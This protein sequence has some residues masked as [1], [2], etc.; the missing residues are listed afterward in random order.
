MFQW[1]FNI[2]GN[3]NTVN[4]VNTCVNNS[5]NNWYYITNQGSTVPA[6]EFRQLAITKS[7]RSQNGSFTNSVTVNGN[8]TV[9]FQIVVTNSGNQ[10]VN[11][12][13]V[14]DYLPTGLSYVSGNDYQNYYVG[15]LMAGQSRT[16]TFQARVNGSVSNGIQ[17]IAR[18]SG[19]S[20]SEVQDDAW[21]FTTNV[22]GGN[23]NL[24]Y[25][26]KAWNDTKNID[27]Q[28]TPA[29]REDYITYTLTVT[30]SG[31][32]PANS[33]VITDDLSQVLPY[34]DIVDNGGGQISGNV[35]T[36]PAV[37]IPSGSTVTKSFKVRV[38][39]YLAQN[40]SYV[41]TNTYGNTVTVRVNTP[42]VLG[43]YVAPKTGADATTAGIF[44]AALTG[45]FAAFKKRETLLGLLL[46]Q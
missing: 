4:N 9:E 23:V 17:N 39:Y 3:N 16:L 34:A 19:D 36:Y 14:T 37:T 13:R 32:T 11:N 21:V 30:N 12:V 7:V 29:A 24:T 27:A 44:A 43:A 42:Q 41:M 25:S 45:L 31:N 20:V 28:S 35:I 2:N 10:V 1:G 26:K 46:G 5:C 15:S 40:L 33:F 22:A 6:N 8:D 18:V 38:K